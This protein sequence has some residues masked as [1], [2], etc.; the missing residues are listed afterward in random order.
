MLHTDDSGALGS[1]PISDGSMNYAAISE[2]GISLLHV[3]Q[4]AML[5]AER[6]EGTS[7][8]DDTFISAAVNRSEML[9][10]NVQNR[11]SIFEYTKGMVEMLHQVL[12]G[13]IEL[14]EF[15]RPHGFQCYLK[16]N[17]HKQIGW[18]ISTK[19]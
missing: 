1:D 4:H 19:I 6:E 16:K 10:E 11:E 8:F 17:C 7:C 14:A 12:L 13:I 3:F 15:I 2:I 9:K 5:C 18:K